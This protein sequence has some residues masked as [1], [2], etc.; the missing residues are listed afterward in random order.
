M[1]ISAGKPVVAPLFMHFPANRLVAVLAV[2]DEML[3]IPVH[4]GAY[5]FVSIE[6]TFEQADNRFWHWRLLLRGT[7]KSKPW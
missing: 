7:G 4:V 2:S 5:R 6:K 3:P 1:A